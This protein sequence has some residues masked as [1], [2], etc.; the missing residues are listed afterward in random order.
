MGYDSGNPPWWTYLVQQGANLYDEGGIGK[1][2]KTAQSVRTQRAA[3]PVSP[4]YMPETS[5]M[6]KAGGP[7]DANQPFQNTANMSVDVPGFYDQAGAPM[8]SGYAK[9]GAPEVKPAASPAA[10]PSMAPSA[11]T[12]AN[13]ALSA[14]GIAKSGGPNEARNAAAKEY[15]V[16]KKVLPSAPSEMSRT[17]QTGQLVAQTVGKEFLNKIPVVGPIVGAAADIAF[18]MHKQGVAD[19]YMKKL[20]AANPNAENLP[21][22]KDANV[23]LTR[24]D[25]YRQVGRAAG[26][27][28]GSYFGGPI[29]G[30]ALS[31]ISSHAD[32]KAA[33][34]AA[35]KS[36]ANAEDNAR[37]VTADSQRRQ[38]GADQAAN[39][40]QGGDQSPD[41]QALA[42]LMQDPQ[43]A[44]F[45]QAFM[46][47]QAGPP[48]MGGFGG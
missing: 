35:K 44:G 21:G 27:A 34:K 2:S 10:S 28:V 5:A 41:Q 9:G 19:K 47:G 26:T 23:G 17:R 32:K 16:S 48:G 22:M 11:S 6:M 20:M 1:K 31:A 36:A 24:T 3:N 38:T 4:G 29:V 7:A 43:M 13:T 45:L 37:L 33:K 39:A 46:G 42:A 40:G 14:Y 15:G 30:S 25:K 18:G 12:I 8:A